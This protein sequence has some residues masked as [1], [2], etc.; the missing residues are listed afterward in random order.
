M[1]NNFKWKLREKK[2][3][4]KLTKHSFAGSFLKLYNEVTNYLKLKN[5]YLKKRLLYNL[6]MDEH[7]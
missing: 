4:L 3:L 2:L 5:R 1:L 6:G 7:H